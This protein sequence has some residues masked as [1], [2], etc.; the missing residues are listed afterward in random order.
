MLQVFDLPFQVP[1][2]IDGLIQ[3]LGYHER[4]RVVKAL[5]ANEDN[6]LPRAEP[7]VGRAIPEIGLDSGGEQ[8]K[9]SEEEGWEGEGYPQEYY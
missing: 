5:C 1:D 3:R 8:G 4:R 2:L 6:I 7:H 9:S